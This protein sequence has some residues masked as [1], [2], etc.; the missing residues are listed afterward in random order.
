M[1]LKYTKQAQKHTKIFYLLLFIISEHILCGVMKTNNVIKWCFMLNVIFLTTQDF[2]LS[3][4]L[5]WWIIQKGNDVFFHGRNT[6]SSFTNNW[7][8]NSFSICGSMNYSLEISLWTFG[9][10]IGVVNQ[11]IRSVERFCKLW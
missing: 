6:S 8:E 11:N 1:S 4:P 10:N 3:F 7:A 2:F 9:T 5:I